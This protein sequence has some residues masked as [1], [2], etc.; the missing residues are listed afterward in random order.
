MGRMV[1][2]EAA[3]TINV[4]I[5]MYNVIKTNIYKK[6]GLEMDFTFTIHEKC[7]ILI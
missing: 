1:M 2:S 7:L 4:A 6:T 3:E 5:I